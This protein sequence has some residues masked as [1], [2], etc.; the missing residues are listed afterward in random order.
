MAE[1]V[2]GKGGNARVW[3]WR[4]GRGRC[5]VYGE[6]LWQEVLEAERWSWVRGFGRW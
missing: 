3:E 6:L 2:A 4:W 5:A 1:A